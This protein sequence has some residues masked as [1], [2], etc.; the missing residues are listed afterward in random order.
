MRRSSFDISFRLEPMANFIFHLTFSDCDIQTEEDASKLAAALERKYLEH[1]RRLDVVL[2]LD[3]LTVNSS[4]RL[5][6]G[7]LRAGLVRDYFRF[8]SRYSGESS[9]R[10]EIFRKFRGADF[11]VGDLLI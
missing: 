6:F 7:R 11:G 1:P 2:N 9:I 8:S 5:L 3:G 4:V 10:Y